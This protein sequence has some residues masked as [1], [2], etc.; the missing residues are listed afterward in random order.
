MSARAAINNM[1]LVK[2][3][4]CATTRPLEMLFSTQPRRTRRAPRKASMMSRATDQSTARRARWPRG[5]TAKVQKARA[6]SRKVQMPEVERWV[7][8]MRVARRGWW[9][10]KSP[11]QRGQLA[12]QPP[13][14]PLARTTA[15][16][17]TTRMNEAEDDPGE[18]GGRLRVASYSQC[19]RA[20]HGAIL[21]GLPGIDRLRRMVVP[22]AAFF[23]G[24]SIVGGSP[25]M[26]RIRSGRAPRRGDNGPRH[27]GRTNA[28]LFF[29]INLAEGRRDRLR[30]IPGGNRALH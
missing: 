4:D 11:L 10:T 3:M 22:E 13:P 30:L 7:N 6:A 1:V 23:E 21:R 15:P 19:C 28:G 8:S 2:W 25:T 16:Q 24:W 29:C 5:V 18:P 27:G 26:T 20:C 14:E 9:G 17:R 12:P